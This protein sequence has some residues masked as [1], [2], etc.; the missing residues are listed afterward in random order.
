MAPLGEMIRPR[1]NFRFVPEYLRRI[2]KCLTFGCNP[3]QT[4]VAA[5]IIRDITEKS[6]YLNA[7]AQLYYLRPGLVIHRLRVPAGPWFPCSEPDGRTQQRGE[8]N[9][10]E[11]AQSSAIIAALAEKG[12]P[13]LLQYAHEEAPS[14]VQDHWASFMNNSTQQ[15]G[16][17]LGSTNVQVHKIPQLPDTVSVYGRFALRY[18]QGKA[19]TF[20]VVQ[21]IWSHSQMVPLGTVTY[22]LKSLVDRNQWLPYIRLLAGETEKEAKEASVELEKLAERVTWLEKQTWDRPDAVEDMGAA[23]K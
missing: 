5:S 10:Q 19:K 6:H 15:G 16:F 4:R 8:T 18:A 23:K 13:R 21:T 11:Q 22:S 1:R 2:G 14:E 9:W 20:E 7:A 17:R 12:L 3:E